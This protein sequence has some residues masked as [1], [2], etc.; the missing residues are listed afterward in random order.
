MTLREAVDFVNKHY[1][2]ELIEFRDFNLTSKAFESKR[3]PR[4]LFRGERSILWKET[5]STFSRNNLGN[6]LIFEEVNYWLT[7]RHLIS[8]EIINNYA[9]Y[10]FLRE[11]F[12]HISVVQKTQ[13]D[14]QIDLSIASFL[15]HYGF[16]TSFVDLTSCILVAAFFASSR[17]KAKDQGQILVLPSEK[18]E[19]RIFDLT[20]E[21]ANR[22]KRQKAF[23]IQVPE[24]Y[25]LKSEGVKSILNPVWINFE[26]TEE[27]K[28]YFDDPNLLSTKEDQVASAIIDWFET[29]VNGNV[30]IGSATKLYFERII[31]DLKKMKK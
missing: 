31:S 8:T 21:A 4:F 23:S 30:D 29:H 11:Q 5:K 9:L 17:A 7:G 28:M 13:P 16:D 12:W 3:Y 6:N 27:D 14:I 2:Q 19:G 24:H 15:Q 25:D 20:L 22:P 26:L 10:F 1:P 18:L